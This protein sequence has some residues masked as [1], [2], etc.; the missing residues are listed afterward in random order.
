LKRENTIFW[1]LSTQLWF[2]AGY[3]VQCFLS[4][5]AGGR[6]RK[7]LKIQVLQAESPVADNYVQK[8]G[9]LEARTPVLN[10][11]QTKNIFTQ[12]KPDKYTTI[13]LFG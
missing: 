4:I 12:Q 5:F 9:V 13:K 7:A 8:K 1:G 11:K 6:Y 2:S 10:Y 3:K